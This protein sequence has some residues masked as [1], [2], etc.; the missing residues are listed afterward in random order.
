MNAFF[1]QIRRIGSYNT[2]MYFTLIQSRIY[3]IM[4]DLNHGDSMNTSRKCDVKC[5]RRTFNGL[6]WIFGQ[7]GRAR[8]SV[9][10]H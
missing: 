4:L 6:Q 5:K 10:V 9:A 7:F 2:I 3:A 1:C 8:V